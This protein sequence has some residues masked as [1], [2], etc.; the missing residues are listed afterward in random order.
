[1]STAPPRPSTQVWAGYNIPA[2]YEGDDY[3]EVSDTG[4][5][6]TRYTQD[7][8]AQPPRK[9]KATVLTDQLRQDNNQLDISPAECHYSARGNSSLHLEHL[10][11]WSRYTQEYE[12]SL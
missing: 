3:G 6:R 1:M 12:V 4:L 8:G 9:R 5:A 7:A 11:P 2:A 10:S